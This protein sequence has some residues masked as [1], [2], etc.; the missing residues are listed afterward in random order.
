MIVV[1]FSASGAA[2]TFVFQGNGTSADVSL[3]TVSLNGAD[4]ASLSDL[5]AS[6]GAGIQ[7]LSGRVQIDLRG[8]SAWVR[9]DDQ[10]VEASFARFSLNHPV[11]RRGEDPFISVADVPAF[12]DKAFGVTVVVHAPLTALEPSPVEDPVVV[13]QPLVPVEPEE[14]PAEVN[15]V[16]V[17]DPGHGGYDK[18]VQGA[19]GLL[20]KDFALDM[21][22]RVR[23]M[24]R[25]V[26]K[27]D[28]LISR[29]QDVNR[30]LAQRAEFAAKHNATVL[31]SIHAGA[32]VAPMAAGNEI[33]FMRAG[34]VYGDASERLARS[35]AQPLAADT[36]MDLRGVFDLPCA[37]L[38]ETPV[39]GILVE[40]GCL[41]NPTQEELLG[42][43]EQR[44]KLALALAK[45][46]YAY[47]QVSAAGSGFLDGTA[48]EGGL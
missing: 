43:D 12:F 36:D 17:L 4:Y 38:K 28:A 19:G 47:V 44:D 3:P 18:G 8:R 16:I 39:P 41:T 7:T 32:S 26:Y 20:E 2:T 45:G 24:L 37:L 33:V 15:A 13:A 34:N 30:S 35:V 5:A 11:I 46:I 42:Q 14:P 29:T 10:Q 40:L 25:D 6:A 31:V 48:D 27:V 23:N 21:A 1:A 9:L 22:G